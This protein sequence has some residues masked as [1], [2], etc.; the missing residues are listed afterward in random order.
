MKKP[1][2]FIFSAWKDDERKFHYI[3]IVAE[4]SVLAWKELRKV[5]PPEGA[6]ELSR[7][8]TIIGDRPVVIFNT[9]K[10]V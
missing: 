3:I 6:W 4:D 7:P 5:A 8:S 9:V 10:G 2:S 1:R